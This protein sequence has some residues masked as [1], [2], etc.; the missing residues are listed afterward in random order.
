MQLAFKT[1]QTTPALLTL[2]FHCHCK[3]CFMEPLSSHNLT[4][5]ILW[6]SSGEE[7]VH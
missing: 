6:T 1:P 7:F 2:Q 5:L 4:S 3:W